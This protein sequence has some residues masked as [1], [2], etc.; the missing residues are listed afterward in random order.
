MAA[1]VSLVSLL[2]AATGVTPDGSHGVIGVTHN[3]SHSVTHDGS[4]GVTGVTP[5]GRYGVMS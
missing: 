3:G 2:M 1:M 4:H 5:D